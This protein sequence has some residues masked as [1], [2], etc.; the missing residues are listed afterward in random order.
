MSTDF[1][2]AQDRLNASVLS[3]L[4]NAQPL[5]NGVAC[6]AI[7]TNPYAQSTLGMGMA[8]ASSGPSLRLRTQD[9]PPSPA[10]KPVT[11]NGAAYTIAEHQ[12]DGTGMSVL[13][14]TGAA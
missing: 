11:V 12:P 5:V 9:V 1:A 6:N 10:G 7:F 2:A 14:L 4:S 8:M 3:C 13:I